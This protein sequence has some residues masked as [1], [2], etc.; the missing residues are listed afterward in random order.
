[1]RRDPTVI[2]DAYWSHLEQ[3]EPQVFGEC[4]GCQE[5]IIEGQD[6]YEIELSHGVTEKVHQNAECCMGYVS[7]MSYC[8]TAGE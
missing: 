2:D 8:R 6:F 1:M 3:S 5:D 4:A 7:Q